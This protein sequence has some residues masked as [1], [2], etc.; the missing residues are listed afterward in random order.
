MATVSLPNELNEVLQTHRGETEEICDLF[1][2]ELIATPVPRTIYHYTDDRGLRGIL[3][4]GRLWF[5]N[6]F[7]LN[8]PSE[9]NHGITLALE[10]LKSRANESQQREVSFFYERFAHTM[11]E[12]IEE[13]AH[14]FVC[15]FSKTDED[16]GQWRAYADDGRGYAI[17]FDAS[18]LETAFSKAELPKINLHSAFPV[19]YKDENLCEILERLVVATIP[20]ISTPQ[21]MGL[22]QGKIL[23]FLKLLSVSLALQCVHISLFFKHESYSNER[24][25]RFL[26]IFPADKPVLDLKLRSRPYSLVPYREFDWKGGAAD[27][28]KE[29]VVGPASDPKIEYKFANDCLREFLPDVGSDF[30]KQSDIPYTSVRR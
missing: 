22:E 18:V 24:E 17:G 5:T 28:I 6:I 9:L 25:Y 29:L 8:D 4:T 7:Y 19:T 13:T 30:I 12:H 15:C 27:S 14:F 3:E 23:E 1:I 21:G 20:A 11:N 16:L 2:K 26:Q 10:I